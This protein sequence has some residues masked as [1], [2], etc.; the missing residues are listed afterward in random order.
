[1]DNSENAIDREIS[2][3]NGEISTLN[4]E[5]STLENQNEIDHITSIIGPFGLFHAVI[6]T[7]VGMTIS[8]HYWQMTSNKF[9]AYETDFWC[10]R[11]ENLKNLS[12]E[13]W[14]NVSAPLLE[15]GEFDRCNIFDVTFEKSSNRPE[16]NTKT[17]PCK[18]WEYDNQYFSVR[19]I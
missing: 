9:L 4:K 14:K 13:I 19:C 11:P 17:V 6:Y 18:S 3:N 12:A 7:V 15:N 16:E 1:M 10:S 2:T 8:I 5:I